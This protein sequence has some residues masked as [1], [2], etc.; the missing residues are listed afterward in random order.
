MYRSGWATK[1]G[2]ERILTLPRVH[3]GTLLRDAVASP[4][5]AAP[6]LKAD[7]WKAAVARSDVHLQWDPDHAAGS[8]PVT[9]RALQLVL[10]VETLRRS[11]DERLTNVEDITD[12]VI[13]QR[14]NIRRPEELIT[15]QED[16][17]PVHDPD[18]ARRIGLDSE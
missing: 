13:E 10:R 15:P 12:F 4:A 5:A 2:Q 17:Y 16:V 11:S 1:E 18:T 14:S 3:F 9:R 6:H 8:H 7:E